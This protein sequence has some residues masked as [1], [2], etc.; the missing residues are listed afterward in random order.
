MCCL[1]FVGP[2]LEE[3]MTIHAHALAHMHIHVKHAYLMHT[4]TV[5]LLVL[6]LWCSGVE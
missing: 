6:A 4:G 5:R 3:H 2:R 1:M